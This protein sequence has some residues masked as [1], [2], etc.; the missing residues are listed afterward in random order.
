M[1]CDAIAYWL[2]PVGLAFAP[3]MCRRLPNSGIGGARHFNHDPDC[4]PEVFPLS[5]AV[6]AAGSE[7]WRQIEEL[8]HALLECDSAERAAL[9]ARTEPG[10]RREV[11]SLLQHA[12]RG[13]DLPLVNDTEVTAGRQLGPYE[14]QSLIGAGGMGKVYRAVDMRLNRSVAIKFA[15]ER[16]SDRFGREARAIGR[17][18]HPHI[19]TLYDV[20]PNYMVMEL[21]EGETLDNTLKKGPI[22]IDRVL[23]YGAQIADGLAAA[24]GHGIT[25]RD[26]KPGNI[27][28]TKTGVK[29]LDFGIAKTDDTATRSHA[30]MG[31]PAYMAP[32]QKEG[33]EADA[34]TDIYALGLV[35][36]EMATGRRSEQMDGLPRQLVHVI[37]RCLEV[38]PAERW[39][40]ASDV[41]KELEWAAISPAAVRT[42]T[43]PPWRLPWI[44]AAIATAA[45]LILSFALLRRESAP[46]PGPA[47]FVLS[48]EKEVRVLNAFPVPS[49]KGESFV[50]VGDGPNGGTS[51]WLRPLE[52]VEARRLPGTDGGSDAFWSPDGNWIGF[53]ADGKLKKI[54]PHGGPPQTLA[55]L[56]GLQNA[57]WGPGGDIIY[58]PTN[59]APLFRIRDSGGS[60]QPLTTLNAAL[61]ENS[62]RFPMFLPDGRRFLFTTRCG[63]RANN[64]LFIGSLDSPE[65]TRVMAVESRVNYVPATDGRPASLVYYREGAVVAQPFD[66]NTGKVLGEAM[67][68]VNPVG[69]NAPSIDARFRVSLDGRI[70]IAQGQDPNDTR[71]R[72]FNR[73]GEEAGSVGGPESHIQPRLS[74]GQDRVAYS[75]PD[76]QT[77]N[78]EVWQTEIV[79]GITAPLTTHVAN[80]WHPV[81][82]PDG[83][84]VLFTS[85]RSGA[86]E[87]V[88]YL[89]TSMDPGR[90]ESPI[91]TRNTQPFD[92][93]S[94]GRWMSFGCADLLITPADSLKMFA[95]LET[96]A[97]ECNPRFSPDSQWIAYGSDESGRVEV[98]IRPFSGKPAAATGKIQVS[99]NGGDYAVWGRTSREIFYMSGDGSIF[100]VDLTN[101]GRGQTLPPPVRLFQPCADTGPMGTPLRNEPYYYSFD[102]RDGQRFLVNCLVERPGRFI[103]LMNWA[104][105]K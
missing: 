69:Y 64:A 88:P 5:Y 47:Q 56:P 20:G 35:L 36:R 49:P 13:R 97:R 23:R 94:D 50:F 62:H 31:T 18:N 32:E 48:F 80:D 101:L 2:R 71:L 37:Q 73:N 52:S 1:T 8:F 93:S 57:A 45:T 27:M 11:E 84:Q 86:S 65:V 30:V 81:W 89:K 90:D 28:L 95:F 33:K 3:L 74:P 39:Q 44:T 7:R 41:K 63:E 6:M 87:G 91:G 92:W 17:L 25:H 67:P 103:V 99:N 102:T 4:M 15:Q 105:P 14:I 85:D 104:L 100:A 29:I 79:R 96:P 82:S 53:Y 46:I 9:L 10:V 19:C 58:R 21:V 22:P 61:T 34:R 16:F 76:P 59:R 54:S 38:D 51:L 72:W 66:A 78:R 98:Y 83:R 60:P 12:W 40:A 77:G 43:R 68:I 24:H 55:A 70:V 26:L 42:E 75:R